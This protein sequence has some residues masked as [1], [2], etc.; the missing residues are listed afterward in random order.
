MNKETY[1]KK[2][3]EKLKINIEQREVVVDTI[4]TSYLLAGN[5]YPVVLLHGGGAG[6]VT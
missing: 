3:L 5:G 4:K 1:R 6:G 2:I